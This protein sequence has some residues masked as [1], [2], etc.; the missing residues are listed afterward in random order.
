MF[1]HVGGHLAH[2]HDKIGALGF[3][4]LPGVIDCRHPSGSRPHRIAA[5]LA[6]DGARM[7]IPADPP[8]IPIAKT[9]ADAGH[10]AHGQLRLHQRRSLFDVQFDESADPRRI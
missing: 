6:A 8:H 7:G 9:A 4:R 5:A 1:T 3:K 10:D 2:R